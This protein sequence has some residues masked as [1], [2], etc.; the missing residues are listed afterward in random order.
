MTFVH[1]YVI[2][3]LNFFFFFIAGDY[4][5]YDIYVIQLPYSEDCW[6][7]IGKIFWTQTYV[8]KISK[9]KCLSMRYFSYVANWYVFNFY[10]Y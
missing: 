2:F 4:V 9:S 1:L 5:Y 7:V 6:I 8:S 3:M 10:T